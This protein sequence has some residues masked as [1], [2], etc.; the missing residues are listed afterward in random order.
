MARARELLRREFSFW[1]GR[2]DAF[3]AS[4]RTRGTVV[5]CGVQCTNR[6]FCESARKRYARKAGTE[7]W[8]ALLQFLLR[9]LFGNC[10]VIGH[11]YI[12]TT[13]NRS[14]LEPFIR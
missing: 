7:G 14:T 8:F 2:S 11:G 6:S 12:F 5:N 10:A 13:C 9:W 4:V 1:G 3:N